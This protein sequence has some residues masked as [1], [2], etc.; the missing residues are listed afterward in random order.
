MQVDSVNSSNYWVVDPDRKAL[1]TA[2]FREASEYFDRE[3]QAEGEAA[4]YLSVA[5]LLHVFGTSECEG[6]TV[7]FPSHTLE[8]SK[9]VTVEFWVAFEEFTVNEFTLLGISGRPWYKGFGV[10]GKMDN[11]GASLN[12]IMGD[13][14]IPDDTKNPCV[15]NNAPCVTIGEL[16]T[17][18]HLA[19]SASMTN[20]D[21]CSCATLNQDA[22]KCGSI[23]GPKGMGD[24]F[25]GS[26]ITI[27]AKFDGDKI[28]RGFNGYIRELRAWS[29][30]L[31]K[32][33]IVSLMHTSLRPL[34][35][36]A[37]IGY[38]PLVGGRPNIFL[39]VSRHFVRKVDGD[40]PRGS[41]EWARV[42]ALWTLPICREG[43]MYHQQSKSCILKRKHLAIY[44]DEDA[45]IAE[46]NG[47]KFPEK[48]ESTMSIWAYHTR[49]PRVGVSSEVGLI[50]FGQQIML[51]LTQSGT[52]TTG[53]YFLTAQ[54]G[55]TRADAPSTGEFS[56][57]LHVW[58]HYALVTG[59][60][61]ITIFYGNNPE[62]TKTHTPTGNPTATSNC[63]LGASIH[64][65]LR[66]ASVWTI[67]FT[68]EQMLNLKH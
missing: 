23:V 20:E 38:W 16:K 5:D 52:A 49:H 12:C 36:E 39:D 47:K 66:E 60:G 8:K 46:V 35:H 42:P 58:I 34:E 50:G 17:W 9:E 40:F 4:D 19:C 29:K 65:Y 28:E 22:S 27:G 15:I 45:F 1:N 64:A 61:S 32:E 14:D 10:A 54:Y 55:N 41:H 25:S 48:W 3:L 2:Q 67:A 68:N 21:H 57:P 53:T 24:L 33:S 44:N 59:A 6:P 30:A 11:S 37:L 56:L 43:Y 31:D 13:Y 7:D 26:R 63:I 62:F 51:N 18:H